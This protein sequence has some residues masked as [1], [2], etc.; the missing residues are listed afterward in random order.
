VAALCAGAAAPL[1]IASAASADP[2]ANSICT[3]QYNGLGQVTVFGVNLTDVACNALGGVN[4]SFD[5]A[6]TGPQGAQGA[7]GATGATGPAGPTGGTG[8]TGAAGAPGNPGPQGAQGV[9]GPQGGTGLQ[10]PIGN[11]GGTGLQGV[12]GAI[13]IVGGDGPQGGTGLQGGIGPMGLTG[14][15]PAVTLVVGPVLTPAVGAGT[16]AGNFTAVSAATCPAGT[17][18]LG[19]GGKVALSGGAGGALDSTL[20]VGNSWTA[21]AVVTHA[22]AG[23][24]ISVQAYAFCQ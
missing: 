5:N 24:V 3:S 1:F 2:I 9:T 10:G 18:V 12:T 22:H 11:V 14:G 17:S 23:G 6:G 4:L 13:G 20:P 21:Q 15:V 8:G 7:V 16:F 19:G